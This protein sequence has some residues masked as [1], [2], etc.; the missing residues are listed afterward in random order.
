MRSMWRMLVMLGLALLV[1]PAMAQQQTVSVPDVSGQTIPQ[2]AATLN[3]SGLNVGAQIPVDAPNGAP[4]NTVVGQSQPAGAVVPYGTAIDLN[5]VQPANA[6]LIYDG[7]D[8]TLVNLTDGQMTIDSLNFVTVEGSAASFSAAQVAAA[9]DGDDC[10]QLWAVAR[11]SPKDVAG[12]GSLLWR[13]SNNPALH[14]WT[15]ASGAVRFSVQEAGIE[16]ATCAAAPANSEDSPLTCEFYLAGG[17]AANDSA[18]F[19]YMAYTPRAIVFLNPTSD[20]WLS[21]TQTTLYNYNPGLSA[22]GAPLIPGDSNVLR[23]EFRRNLGQIGRLAPGQCIAYTVAGAEDA[24]LP[25]ECRIVAL[26]SF[27]PDIAFWLAD[28]EVE[29]ATDGERRTC[30]AALEGRLTRCIVPR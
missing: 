18:P 27:T 19:I 29:S 4:P 28:F 1:V 2:A 26:R 6:R 30:P 20:Q 9:L 13:S 11:N 25:E 12:C 17:S 15:Q 24:T 10:L 7:N 14:F 21:T 3:A 8:I 5:V 16:R 22:P 23:E